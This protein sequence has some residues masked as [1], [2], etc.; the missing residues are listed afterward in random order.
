MNKKMLGTLIALSLT[1]SFVFAE[2]AVTATDAAVAA[3]TDKTA[4]TTRIVPLTK[5]YGTAVKNA[6]LALAKSQ[7]AQKDVL[8]EQ[9]LSLPDALYFATHHNRDVKVALAQY[10]SAKASVSVAAAAKNPTFSYG[11]SAGRSETVGTAASTIGN[12]YKNSLTATL[13]LYTGGKTESAIDSARYARDIAG[14]TAEQTV[15]TVRL[16]TA[17]AYFT[18]L[19]A[20]NKADVADMQITDLAEHKRTVDAQ[21]NVGIVAK[22][23]VLATDVQVANAQTAKI[24]A[25]NA[26]N[27]AKVSLNNAL[28]TPVQTYVDLTETEFPYKAYDITEEQAESHALLYRPDVISAAL[29]VEKAKA[30]VT[31]A[32]SGYLPT[33]SAS[34]SKG[35]KGGNAWATDNNGWSIGATVSWDLWDGGA[36]QGNIDVANANLEAAKQTNE[37]TIA[38]A[39]LAVRTAYLNMKAAEATIQSTKVA[40]DQGIENFRIARLR[41]QAGVGTNLDVLDAEYNLQS[42]RNEHIDALYNYNVYVATL[43]NAIGVDGENTVIG[44]G[45]ETEQVKT[46]PAD[47]AALM[48]SLK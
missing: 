9:A 4:T 38:D 45:L 17:K 19:Q 29:A 25:D 15:Q 14:A 7:V 40:V 1:A 16:N 10:E 22:S 2:D 48:A 6:Q 32:K 23:D 3:M 46:A 35:W 34:A 24:T 36:T 8:D 20:E 39:T 27:V 47:L 21:Y 33:V 5:S 28:G 43:E 41:Y 13:P 37:Q 12:S 11:Y 44:S 31:S 42:A 18:L 30:S 26:V